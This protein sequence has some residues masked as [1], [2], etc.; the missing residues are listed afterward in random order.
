MS[1][2]ESYNWIF[3]HNHETPNHNQS[4]FT[5]CPLQQESRHT[6]LISAVKRAQFLLMA[7]GS[8][9]SHSMQKGPTVF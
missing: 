1:D 7:M 5:V 8:V 2:L 6:K 4:I 9:Q 3:K